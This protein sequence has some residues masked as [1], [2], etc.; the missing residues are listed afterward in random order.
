M[1]LVTGCRVLA[2]GLA[3]GWRPPGCLLLI[4]APAATA[5]TETASADGW[6]LAGYLLLM[7]RLLM[8][9]SLAEGRLP[10]AAGS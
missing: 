3:A 4:A 1:L 8:L 5:T 9:L 6:L 2:G 7:L 10:L